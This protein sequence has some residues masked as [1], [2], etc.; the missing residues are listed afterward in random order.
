[1][2]P[3]YT[4][5]MAQITLIINPFPWWFKQFHF[6]YYEV[7]RPCAEGVIEAS[8]IFSNDVVS[9]YLRKLWCVNQPYRICSSICWFTELF[10]AYIWKRRKYSEHMYLLTYWLASKFTMMW[11]GKVLLVH[12]SETFEQSFASTVHMKLLCIFV[13]I[14]LSRSIIS[15][16]IL[17]QIMKLNTRHWNRIQVT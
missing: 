9:L 10:N 13:G 8:V 16:N 5:E 15:E 3:L 4:L 1:M 12:K 14:S 17:I 11:F 2:H 7:R 6:A